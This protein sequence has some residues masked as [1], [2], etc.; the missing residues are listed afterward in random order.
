MQTS[1]ATACLSG[2]L[3]DSLRS[4]VEAGPGAVEPFQTLRLPFGGEHHGMTA[5]AE[6][7]PPVRHVERAEPSHSMT[8]IS[9]SRHASKGGGSSF[10]DPVRSPLR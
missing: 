9:T 8:T 6:G 2:P 1:I 4:A 5:S 7:L 3:G 10:R